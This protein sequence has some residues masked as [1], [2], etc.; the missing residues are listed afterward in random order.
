MARIFVLFLCACAL[1]V[2]AQDKP[3]E[4]I[5]SEKA[6]PEVD[7]ALRARVKQFYQAHVDAKYRL[8][9]QVVAEES[10]DLFFAAAKPKY[11]GFEIVRINFMDNFTK[12]EATV[13]CKGEWYMHGQQMPVTMPVTSNWK[14]INGEWFW[15]IIPV[16]TV[17]TPFGTMN[18]NAAGEAA[19]NSAPPVPALPADPHVLAARILSQVKLD[20]DDVQLSSYEPSSAEIHIS[21][22]MPGQITL[23]SE[24]DGAFP[25]LKVELD[26]TQV[27]PRETATL[28]ITC[29]PKDRAPKPTLTARVYVETTNQVLPVKITFA[30][31]PEM[32][33]LIPKSARPVAP[34][35][36]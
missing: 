22:G 1:L 3:V 9:D 28:K 36:P 7:A 16:T 11:R 23:R 34:S 10:K 32:E 17:K 4:K 6:P 15:Y 2:S 5:P 27:G 25:G 20:R 33:K 24:I 18:Y 14:L 35:E 12:A 26:K 13:A 31:P 8:A 30:I 21:N 29:D 19:A